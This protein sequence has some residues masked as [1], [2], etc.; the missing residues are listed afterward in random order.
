MVVSQK[1]PIPDLLAVIIERKGCTEVLYTVSPPPPYSAFSREAELNQTVAIMARL[2][3]LNKKP[4][5]WGQRYLRDYY[6]VLNFPGS[7]DIIGKTGS[8]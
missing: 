2:T 4:F 6:S 3:V 1:S 7:R 8:C 5:V